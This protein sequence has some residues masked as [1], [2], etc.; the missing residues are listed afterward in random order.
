MSGV[1]RIIIKGVTSAVTNRITRSLYIRGQSMP[2]G[3]GIVAARAYL[4]TF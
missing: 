2:F 1:T 3:S 4:L